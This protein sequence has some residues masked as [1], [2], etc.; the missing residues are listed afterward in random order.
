M[1]KSAEGF[2]L[3][4]G[5][6]RWTACHPE[7]WSI[8]AA[9][10]AWLALL[11][12]LDH[13]SFPVCSSTSIGLL[14]QTSHHL[15]MEYGTGMLGGMLV[16]WVTMMAAMTPILAIPMVRIVA[17][18]SFGHRRHRAVAIFLAGAALSWCAS[19]FGM[20]VPMVAAD[21]LAPGRRSVA[22]CAFLAAAAWQITSQKRRALLACHRTVPLAAFGWRAD[23]D[24]LG[25]GWSYGVQCFLSCWLMM[26]ASMLTHL[27]AAMLCV[28]IVA[29][30]E[31]TSADA[32]DA[33]LAAL[34]CC[35]VLP[36]V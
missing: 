14:R 7:W 8:A 27:L 11:H 32:R 20:L 16:G 24:C 6:R 28:Q 13:S 35:A 19:G 12:P 29:I 10:T 34:T 18:R 31:R 3:I 23:V 1:P 33:C 25:V 5:V 9:G 36:F 26:L 2:C 15:R 4:G 21:L 30:R 17:A 22:A